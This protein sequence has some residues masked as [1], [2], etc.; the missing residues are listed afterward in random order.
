MFVRSASNYI[1][2]LVL[3]GQSYLIVRLSV[4]ESFLPTLHSTW[5]HISAALSTSSLV[6][7]LFNPCDI[8]V[9]V[10]S[11]ECLAEPS[12]IDKHTVQARD[13]VRILRHFADLFMELVVEK[14]CLTI[15][16]TR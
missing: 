3:L 10:W 16:E 11:E 5:K 14:R 2:E 8:C 4:R 6:N 9:C 1:D 7:G 12:V 15:S 13:K